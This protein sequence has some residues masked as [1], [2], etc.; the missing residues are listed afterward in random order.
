MSIK[1]NSQGFNFANEQICSPESD[2]FHSDLLE[3]LPQTIEVFTDYY[4]SHNRKIIEEKFSQ[5]M[6][7][8]YTSLYGSRVMLSQLSPDSTS[9]NIQREIK[10][11]EIFQEK[12]DKKLAPYG[13]DQSLFDFYQRFQQP[14]L[15]SV[16]P[17]ENNN[18]TY[19]NAWIIGNQILPFPIIMIDLRDSTDKF[20][21]VV[22]HEL[23]HGLASF[24][25]LLDKGWKKIKIGSGIFSV[26]EKYNEDSKT[27]ETVSKNPFY[28]LN[29]AINE[30]M[31]R[32]I[33]NTMHQR[34]IF[35]RQEKSNR[36]MYT[37]FN[38][39]LKAVEELFQ[40]HISLIKD[41]QVQGNFDKL[42]TIVG[43]KEL[44]RI[45]EECK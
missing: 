45:N 14:T 43:E 33:T 25:R 4:G 30:K 2:P 23:N 22:N 26:E 32:D 39:K 6:I 36:Q 21:Y 35:Y 9:E 1:E 38:Q 27:F 28:N 16:P 15:L 31:A 41:C 42:A 44:L 13:Y 37:H 11:Q 5:F 12:K 20:D 18:M 24:V 7:V 34:G 40:E 3:K 8:E 29:E 17:F 10:R 19:A